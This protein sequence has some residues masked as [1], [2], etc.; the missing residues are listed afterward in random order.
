LW[1]GCISGA[2]DEEEYLDIIR[3]TGF[4]DIEVHDRYESG[5]VKKDGYSLVSVTIEAVKPKLL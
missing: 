5:S 1:T 2:I 3:E 4:C